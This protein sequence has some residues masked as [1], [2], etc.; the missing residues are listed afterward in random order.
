VG[1]DFSYDVFVRPERVRDLL[2][3]VAEISRPETGTTTLELPDGSRFVGPWGS[4]F[5][6]GATIRLT[7]ASSWASGTLGMSLN[8]REDVRLLEHAERNGL[9]D[10]ILAAWPDGTTRV[11]IGYVYVYVRTCQDELLPGHLCFSFMPATSEQ[12]RLFLRSGSIRAAFVELCARADAPLCLFDFEYGYHLAI[13]AGGRPV[14][15]RPFFYTPPALADPVGFR[16]WL[17]HPTP[18]V[19]WLENEDSEDYSGMIA[20]LLELA[21]IDALD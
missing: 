13:A 16:A 4:P 8:F 5:E 3:A 14:P 2:E 21:G 18:D 6:S 11:R 19:L 7:D 15:G 20:H 1:I 17:E 12:S 10:H 9:R